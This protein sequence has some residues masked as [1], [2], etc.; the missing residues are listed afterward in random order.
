MSPDEI[1]K[2]VATS[3]KATN[4]RMPVVAGTGFNMTL[5]VEIAK[6]VAKAGAE[7]HSCSA[8]LLRSGAGRR[9]VRVLRSYRESDRFAVDGL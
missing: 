2:V 5:G 6:R 9:L 1:E 4:G 8:S 3:V 7:L